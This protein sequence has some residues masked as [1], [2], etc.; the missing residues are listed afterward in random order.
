MVKQ[1]LRHAL[2]SAG[3]LCLVLAAPAFAQQGQV[4]TELENQVHGC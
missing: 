1:E 3:L 2:L 4:L